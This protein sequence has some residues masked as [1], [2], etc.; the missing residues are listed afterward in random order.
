MD[1]TKAVHTII[2]LTTVIDILSITLAVVALLVTIIGF[3]AS[4]KFYMEG[5]KL[6]LRCLVWVKP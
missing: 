1:S 4:L 2:N 3:F 5:V 6:A